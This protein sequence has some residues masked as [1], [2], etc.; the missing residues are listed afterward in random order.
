[1][2]RVILD[3]NIFISALIFKGKMKSILDL[4]QKNRFEVIVCDELEYE[5]LSKFLNKFEVDQETVLVLADFFMSCRSVKISKNC[6][7][8]IRDEKDAY[9]LDLCVSTKV[10]YLITGDKDL[11]VLPKNC[12]KHTKIVSPKEFLDLVN[13]GI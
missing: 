5:V 12:L 13:F 1:M 7:I 3:A 4:A 2:L 11:L 6:K 10:D 8:A 9:L